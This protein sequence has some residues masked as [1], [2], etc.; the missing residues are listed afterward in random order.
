[1]LKVDTAD[2]DAEAEL[3]EYGFDSVSL[4]EFANCLSRDFGWSFA[5]LFS[6]I[7]L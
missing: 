2:V 3:N 4:T 6:N 7:R 5:T 1:M